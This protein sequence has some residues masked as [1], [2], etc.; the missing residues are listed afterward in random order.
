[1]LIS[2][3]SSIYRYILFKMEI[4][5]LKLFFMALHFAMKIF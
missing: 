3:K 5:I 1:M 2:E 4:P